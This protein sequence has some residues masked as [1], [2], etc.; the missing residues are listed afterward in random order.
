M[1]YEKACNILNIDKNDELSDLYLK[2]KYRLKAL[3]YHPDKC[4]DNNAGKLFI[5]IQEAYQYLLN[6]KK[7]EDVIKTKYNNIL[8]EFL[9][10]YFENESNVEIVIKIINKSFIN[11]VVENCEYESIL[12]IYRF[13]REYGELFEVDNSILEFL[14]KRIDTEIIILN[15]SLDDILDANIF[16]LN[17][18]DLKLMIPLWHREIYYE[19]DNSK[20]L[21]VR[22]IPELSDNIFIDISNN[23]H[24]LVSKEEL[25][26]IQIGSKKIRFDL[27]KNKNELRL[28]GEG[29]NSINMDVYNSI[30]QDII[31]HY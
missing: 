28:V 2:K 15:P 5:E 19:L 30:K 11:Y 27:E 12:N 7:S 14:K 29:I 9:K 26:E 20:T 31:I 8:K 16:I 13:L 10:E 6:N 18:N 24:I 4:R 22:C 1:N 3:K 21:L 17:Y 23:L 25:G